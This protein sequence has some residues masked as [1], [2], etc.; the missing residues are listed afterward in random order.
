M[1]RIVLVGPAYPYRGGQ[2]LVEAYVFNTLTQM[3]YD[4]HTVSY[5]LLYPS[6]LFP[7]TT[8]FDDSKLIPF[9]HTS[10]I[11]RLINSVNPLT[12]YKAAR[13]ITKLNPDGVIFVWWMPFFGP[14]LGTIARLLKKKTK[15]IFLVENYV[16]HEKRWFDRFYTKKTLKHA[17]AFISESGYVT[18]QVTK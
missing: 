8:Q 5:S 11:R 9:E 1:K 12:W 2:A 10:R 4:C 15:I 13:E 7:G 3:G 14:A 18:S 17:H 6:I 16:S